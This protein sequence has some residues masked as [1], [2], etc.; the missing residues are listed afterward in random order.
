VRLLQ[1]PELTAPSSSLD[2]AVKGARPAFSGPALEYVSH[3]VYD[4]YKLLPGA[5]FDGPAIVE[6][7]ESTVIVGEEASASVDQYG[8]L[9]I[10]LGQ[11]GGRD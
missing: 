1:L 2:D 7:R 9:W 6:E 11:E 5:R 3:T 10:D 8:F 4:R